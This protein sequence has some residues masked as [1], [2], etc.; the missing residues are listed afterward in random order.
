MNELFSRIQSAQR[1][2]TPYLDPTPLVRSVLL[3][4]LT[5]C[6][7]FLKC[8]HFQQT[9][10]FKSRGA[11]HKLLAL[12]PQARA[13]GVITAST[14][15]HGQ[16]VA[17]AGKMLG[18]PVTVYVPENVIRFKLDVMR[19]LGAEV[20]LI[21]GDPLLGELEARREAAR[22]GVPYVAP[23]NDLD[24]VAGQ[25]TAGLEMTAQCA[26]L[27]AVFVTVGGGGLI[28]G[29]GTA[30]KNASP[31]TRVVGCWPIASTGMYRSLD[32]GHIVAVE[33]TDTLSE[34]STGNIE[35]GSVTFDLC[36]SVID[37]RVLIDE[38]EIRA[39]MRLLAEN[40]RWMVEGAAGVAFAGLLK[41]AAANPGQKLAAVVCGRNIMLDRFMEA[42]R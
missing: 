13:R 37:D 23:Y 36:R 32:A 10:S 30:F 14:G 8:E 20:V 42:V 39:A 4:R 12:G 22:R 26:D 6:E 2:L 15:N 24:V 38:P 31:R 11:T 16:G 27:D 21:P 7:V 33:E 29:I 18:V 3:S 9:G 1:A 28:S 34:S 25:G 35:P 40:E 5:G 19:E 17:W 41:H